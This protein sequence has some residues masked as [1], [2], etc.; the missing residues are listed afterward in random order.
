MI[1]KILMAIGVLAILGVIVVGGF[2]YYAYDKFTSEFDK[3][4]PEFR[5]YV[6]MTNE[7][8]NNYVV[9]NLDELQVSMLPLFGADSADIYEVQT[10][11]KEMDKNPEYMQ[12]KINWGRSL[13]A[14]VI[15]LNSDEFTK[16]LSPEIL[17]QLQAENDEYEVRLLEYRKQM[18]LYKSNQK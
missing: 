10:L 2:S 7:E 18:N 17:K 6:T 13:V 1:K 4:V 3:R 14:R 9:K 16:N 15:L 8:Q 11:L 5:Q 12:A